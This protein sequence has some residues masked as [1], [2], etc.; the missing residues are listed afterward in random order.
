MRLIM[1]GKIRVK[2]IF[3]I[4]VSVVLM[5][6]ILSIPNCDKNTLSKNPKHTIQSKKHVTPKNI[7]LEDIIM[8]N[9]R[10]IGSEEPYNLSEGSEEIIDNGLLNE[11]A[12]EKMGSCTRA[13]D[14]W[15][16]FKDE[17]E[18]PYVDT[19]TYA[20]IKDAYIN[21]DFF[22]KFEMG[23]QEYYNEYKEIYWKVLCNEKFIIDQD[24]SKKMLIS[25]VP[26]LA[27]CIESYGIN[28]MVYYYFDVDGDSFP[29]LCIQY[30]GMGIYILD[31]NSETEECSLWYDL[32]SFNYVLI[33]TQKVMWR[34]NGKFFS[35]YLLNEE[36]EEECETFFFKE[37]VSEEINIC[38][39]ML[40]WYK[41]DAE[42]I[43]VSD[44]MNECAIYARSEERWYFRVTEQQYNELTNA[45][46]ESYHAAIEGIKEVTYNYE[47]LFGTFHQW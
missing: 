3:V 1:I 35:F 19:E 5:V 41:D 44:H 34:G 16:D 28:N 11:T 6:N 18:L 36:W 26:E 29:E 21:I 22:G 17:Y 7:I 2:L 46:K 20:I 39:V 38:I 4:I 23:N 14:S 15:M 13:Y 47:E 33:G 24:S 32:A 43:V 45:Y 10:G 8:N 9:E 12:N 42:R 25:D 27:D 40:P 30:Y 37:P 31:Y